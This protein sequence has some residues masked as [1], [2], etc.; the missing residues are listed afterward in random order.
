[1]IDQKIWPINNKESFEVT[2]L[3]DAK[4]GKENVVLGPLGGC[5]CGTW[6]ITTLVVSVLAL[7]VGI[8]VFCTGISVHVFGTLAIGIGAVRF[9]T[10]LDPIALAISVLGIFI[11]MGQISLIVPLAALVIYVGASGLLLLPGAYIC[12][13]ASFGA[14]A[15][16]SMG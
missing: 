9:M 10:T 2:L 12:T 7:M 16:E 15:M 4:K 14:A 11:L 6:T 3:G 1:M 8:A 5:V 13:S